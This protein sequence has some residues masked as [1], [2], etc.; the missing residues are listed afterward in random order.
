[1]H[2]RYSRIDKGQ[3]TRALGGCVTGLVAVAASAP[4]LSLLEAV[5]VGA[6]AGII[7]NIG[8]SLLRKYVLHQAWQVR[9]AYMV[10]IH[11]LGGVW[12]TLCVVMFGSEGPS[13]SL[14]AAQLEGIVIALVYSVALA[15][16]VFLLFGLYKRRGAVTH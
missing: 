3:M 1:M 5:L 16:A 13:I 4:T 10:A 6:I 7:H 14:L 11:G 8:F 2:Y 15:N 12:G 9:T